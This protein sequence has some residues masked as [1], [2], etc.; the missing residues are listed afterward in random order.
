MVS[1]NKVDP[2]IH[3]L[4]T[5]SFEPAKCSLGD[6]LRESFVEQRLRI[7]Q[8]ARMASARDSLVGLDQVIDT[9]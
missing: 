5:S 7:L 2:K 6:L 1:N 3:S 8:A 9:V 4:D